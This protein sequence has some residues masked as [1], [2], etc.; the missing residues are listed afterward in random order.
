MT[1][2]KVVGDVGAVCGNNDY[3]D[4]FNGDDFDDDDDD[5]FYDYFDEA[6]PLH[7]YIDTPFHLPTWTAP[8]H[9]WTRSNLTFC[10]ERWTW[11]C[12]W[13]R[14]ICIFFV[15]I[16]GHKHLDLNCTIF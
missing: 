11:I 2:K 3:G 6:I 13:T 12:N 10:H 5:D 4:D 7:P 15:L 1:K 16:F 14:S 8:P 9:N